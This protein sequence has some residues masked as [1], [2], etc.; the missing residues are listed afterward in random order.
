M[1]REQVWKGRIIHERHGLYSAAEKEHWS[2]FPLHCSVR[3]LTEW[4]RRIAL[5]TI[6]RHELVCARVE[7][8]CELSAQL[9]ESS[10]VSIQRLKPAAQGAICQRHIVITQLSIGWERRQSPGLA[11]R[12]EIPHQL[13]QGLCKGEDREGRAHE[14]GG[15]GQTQECEGTKRNN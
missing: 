3:L 7:Q 6:N 8:R 15:D 10:R 1:Q 5:E 9:M 14:G 12:T 13:A 4:L 11:T 2:L